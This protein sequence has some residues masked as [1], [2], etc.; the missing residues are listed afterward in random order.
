M[1]RVVASILLA[2]IVTVAVAQSPVRRKTDSRASDLIG[3]LLAASK[4]DDAVAIC[5]ARLR[6]SQLSGDEYAFWLI[7]SSRVGIVKSLRDDSQDGAESIRRMTEYLDTHANH[8]RT[9]WLRFQITLVEFASVRQSIMSAI[10]QPNDAPE[11]TKALSDIVRIGNQLLELSSEIE[12][13]IPIAQ[14]RRDGAADAN[15]LLALAVVVASQRIEALMMRGEMFAAGSDDMIASA[16]EAIEA[17]G[18]LRSSLAPGAPAYDDLTRSLAESLRRVGDWESARDVIMPLIQSDSGDGAGIAIAARI[19]MDQE[20]TATAKILLEIAPEDDVEVS[21]AKLQLA[22]LTAKESSTKGVGTREIGDGIERIGKSFGAHARRRAE[23][24]A[25]GKSSASSSATRDD[26]DPRL[27]IAQAAVRVRE[28]KPVEAGR[29]LAAAARAA[30]DPADALMLATAGAAAL[31]A[32]AEVADASALLR[33]TALA[34]FQTP[35]AAKLHLQ[36]AILIADIAVPELIIEQMTECVAT[37]PSD[38]VAGMATDWKV[39]LLDARGEHAE[40]ARA[41]H[42]L[43][44]SL[45]T[46]ERI[47]VAKDQL[48]NGLLAMSVS[49]RAGLAHEA[50]EW[51]RKIGSDNAQSIAAEIATLFADAAALASVDSKSVQAPW[52]RWVAEIRAGRDAVSP[53]MDDV[54]QVLRDAAAERFVLDSNVNSNRRQSIGRAILSLVSDDSMVAA[55]AHGWLREWPQVMS[56]IDLNRER[57]PADL[58]LAKRAATMLC[59]FDNDDMRSA[60]IDGWQRIT[61]QLPQGSREWHLAKL[62]LVDALIEVGRQ[63]EAIRVAKYVLATQTPEDAGMLKRY[64]QVG[65]ESSTLP[66][67]GK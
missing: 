2:S 58:E 37:W 57:S 3:A 36:S 20:D 33:E 7:Q 14:T 52:L 48:I 66:R 15:E 18:N 27:L 39:R 34:R 63:D 4:L 25:I 11:R 1:R 29:F 22:I 38:E 16:N 56:I 32:A 6:E 64:E 5:D 10:V 46:D 43:E 54:P 8:R 67:A 17:A 23:R 40:A 28:G 53:P 30:R 45:L 49:T 61:T 47:V 65:S 9:F 50:I 41:M 35:G 26:L 60:G 31:R 24:L 19:A 55:Q 44:P 21:L 13:A 12:T 51:L 59:G 62:S 42:T